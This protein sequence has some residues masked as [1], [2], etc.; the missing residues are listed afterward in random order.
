MGTVCSS[1]PPLRNAVTVFRN[2]G[3]DSL[4]FKKRNGPSN[5]RYISGPFPRY[6]LVRSSVPPFLRYFQLSERAGQAQGFRTDERPGP[7][8]HR[9]HICAGIGWPETVTETSFISASP[10]GHARVGR[11][12][13]RRRLRRAAGGGGGRRRLKLFANEGENAADSATFFVYL[14][15]HLFRT[16]SENF[17]SRSPQVT[18]PGEVK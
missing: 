6:N 1:V 7:R 3:T 12:R 15:I 17:S 4:H 8:S 13:P 18:S 11:T 10:P 14:F 9:R 16:L 2:G 5:F